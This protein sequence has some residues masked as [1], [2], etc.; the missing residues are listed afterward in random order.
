MIDFLL[1]NKEWLFSG[2]GVAVIVALVAIFRSRFGARTTLQLKQLS[3]DL[4][5]RSRLSPLLQAPRIR[6][7]RFIA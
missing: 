1:K 6:R 4:R 2:V 5:L 7:F 3:S